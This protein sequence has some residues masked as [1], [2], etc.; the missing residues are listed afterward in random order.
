M[1]T[2]S[3][4]KSFLQ[5]D[6]LQFSDPF[7]MS[8]MKTTVDRI[9]AAKRRGEKVLVHG[10]YDADGITATT[11]MLSALKAVGIDCSFF[12]PNRIAHGYGFKKAGVEQA[13][14]LGVSLVITVD[15]GISSF[16]AAAACKKEG[17]D[18]IITDHHEPA[19]AHD[20]PS[21]ERDF[22]LPEA[23]AVVNPRIS[24]RQ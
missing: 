21:S 14:Q 20:A 23:I 3:E 16:D 6:S 22:S 18:V 10:D 11:I 5:A 17:M 8:G 7:G 2:P 9:M 19:S 15:C 12:I 1:K 4:V 24:D 13:R